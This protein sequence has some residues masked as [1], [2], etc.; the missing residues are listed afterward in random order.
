MQA[1]P[2]PSPAG[3]DRYRGAT[4][5]PLHTSR[6]TAAGVGAG[7]AVAGAASRADSLAPAWRLP[8]A[9]GGADDGPHPEQALSAAY[10]TCF[11]GALC[12]MA[13]RA[14]LPG[15]EAEVR[16]T[17]IFGRDPVDGQFMLCAELEVCLPGLAPALAATLVREAERL[18]PYTKLLKHGAPSTVRLRPAGPA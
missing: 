13:A 15:L 4:F 10:A 18:C 16:A 6:F 1:P 14:S 2:T 3:S 17:V 8:A 11:H 9:L 12:L 5:L 7:P